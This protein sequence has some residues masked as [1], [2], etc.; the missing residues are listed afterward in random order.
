M[1]RTLSMNSGSVESLKVSARCGCTP[2]ARQVRFTV[3]GDIPS[4]L[5]S[6]RYSNGSLGADAH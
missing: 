4:W 2:K 1:S 6:S 3:L 5:A